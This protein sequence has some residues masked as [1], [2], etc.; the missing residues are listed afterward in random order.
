MFKLELFK[1]QTDG[2]M[3]HPGLPDNWVYTIL[4]AMLLIIAWS[5]L[6]TTPAY[7]PRLLSFRRLPLVGGVLQHMVTRPWVLLLFRVIFVAIFLLVIFS[8]LFGTPIPERN[9][10]TS[11]TWTLW[12]T[13]LIIATYF[14]GSAWCAVCPWDVL[15]TWLVRLRLWQR[16]TSVN[17]LNLRVPK[18]L[19]NIWVASWM[20]IILTWLELGFGL[21]ISPYGTA[22]LSLV[23]V[24]LAL[25]SQVIY[26][27]KAFCR[28][29]CSVGRTIGFYASL[30]PL[31]IRPV[32][33]AIC[34][35]CKTLECFRGNKDIEPCPTHMVIGRSKQNTFCT[36][37][38]ACT[39]SCPYQ[40]VN[41]AIRKSAE[42]AIYYVRPSW[43][44]SWFILILVTL[45]S[46]HGITMLPVWE[47]WISQWAR[48]IGDSGQLLWSFSS[49]MLLSV[50]IPIAVFALFVKLF[51]FLLRDQDAEFKRLFAVFGLP[52]LPL[53]F[54]YHLAHNLN[55]LVR[56]SRG[57]T[58]VFLNPLG[59]NTL[60][61]ALSELHI[62]HT[63]PLISQG[64][65]NALQ[66]GLMITGFWFAVR[67]LQH[68]LAGLE[69][70]K[71][72]IQFS[73][74]VGMLVLIVS[75][76]L[77]NLWLLIQP[78]VMRMFCETRV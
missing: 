60:P 74:K 14:L 42:E 19:R 34:A 1:L 25:L 8:G 38:G 56:E 48:T 6:A 32:D 61:L 68:R 64:V 50:G 54:G 71:P 67:I 18:Y 46:F 57:I 75:V 21:T 55:H 37:C 77:F 44:E 17:S 22:I 12:W 16:G 20:F 29:F 10:A 62:R 43:D 36:S 9:L 28:Y 59:T 66:A 30:S 58:D 72:V 69:I 49:G 11:L 70:R 15:A 35:D 4:L 23:V 76:T 47:K 3:M 24:V 31:A 27:R 33:Q 78:M 51:Q 40:N 41:W 5:F 26:E 63:S 52:F 2:M 39:Q 73:I 45:T 65:L 13:G 7:K 53:A